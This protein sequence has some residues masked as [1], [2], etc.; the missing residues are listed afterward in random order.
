MMAEWL[1][2]DGHKRAAIVFLNTSWGQGL[3]DEFI[4]RFKALG[5]EIVSVEACNEGDRNL[6][7]Q[8]TKIKAARRMART[9]FT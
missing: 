6:R 5:G 2:E 1:K 4:A 8:I 7:A 3:K 9:R